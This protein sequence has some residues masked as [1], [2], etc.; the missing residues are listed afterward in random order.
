MIGRR[1]GPY[2]VLAKLGEGGMGE[3]YRA[4]DTRLNRDV[5]I[6]ILPDAFASDADR[7]ARFAR[8]AQTLASLNHPHIAQIYGLEQSSTVTALVMEL[9]EG[10][11]LAQRIARGPIPVDEALAIA[12]QLADG[13]EAAHEKGIIHRDLKPANIKL[14][15]DGTVKVLDFGLAKASEIGEREPGRTGDLAN[16]PTM[17]APAMTH[18]GIILG[19]AAYMSPE[20]A[21]GKPVDK[22][23]DIWAFGCVLYEML[24]GRPPFHGETVTDTLASVVKESA[25]LDRLPADT[26][27]H[28]QRLIERCLQK[29]PR[30]RLR[31]IGDAR[32]DLDAR[33]PESAPVAATLS[34]ARMMSV[35]A[36]GV[37]IGASVAAASSWALLRQAPAP[38]PL[39]TRFTISPPPG[40]RLYASAF[41][42]DIA[43]SA[44][45]TRV[46][47]RFGTGGLAIRS[48]DQLEPQIVPGIF[49]RQPVFSPDGRWIAFV[50]QSREL[51]KVSIA[52]GP[53][54]SICLMPGVGPRGA[55]WGPDEII[56]FA[57]NDPATGLLSVP[58]GGGDPKVLT[59]PKV[60]KD[61]ALAAGGV[62]A[63][64]DHL[65]PSLLPDGRGV[66]FTV[67]EGSIEKAQIAVLDLKTGRWKTVL[68]G[69]AAAE[70]VPSGHLVYAGAGT[71]RAV[72]FDPDLMDVVGDPVS[73]S[74][75]VSLIESTGA[76][77]FAV[78]PSGT[79]AY[80][81]DGAAR[82]AQR[83]LVWVDRQG[84]EEPVGAPP[85][86][87][88]VARIA[89]DATRIAV[90]TLDLER[91]IWNWDTTRR[92]LTRLTFGPTQDDRPVWM[93]EGRHIIFGSSRMSA[94]DLFLRA[95]DGAGIDEPLASSANPKAVTQV[96]DDGL[97]AIGVEF[98][99]DTANDIVQWRIAGRGNRPSE[100][101]LAT[102]FQESNPAIS[103]DGRYLA[104]QSDESGPL[105]VYVR[106]YPKVND[107]RWQV[108]TAG[109][110][111]PL[112]SPNGRELFYVAADGSLMVVPVHTSGATFK[113][114]NP[115]KLIEGKYIMTSGDR[116]YD[117]SPDGKRFLMIK[118]ADGKA[119][120]GAS[121]SC[122]TSMK[123]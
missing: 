108:S 32:L 121:S 67:W 59:T 113:Q 81:P 54:V 91:D 20:Q 47:F 106:P 116:Q 64:G 19:T 86:T 118:D 2:E 112:W 6:K 16:S 115:E 72:R 53:A 77:N 52:G 22:R 23:A 17:A 62:T 25:D 96:T 38:L 61:A 9:V 110:T 42:R 94:S 73:L 90:S 30:M 34:R 87:Y 79:V 107:G 109:G 55:A 63:I 76:A 82:G 13:L 18:A 51:K 92:T 4:R 120:P 69:G 95:A 48:I 105:E 50:E 7:V 89:P 31:D 24:T 44:D 58:A 8:E 83:S 85:R 65:F 36:A 41:D 101:L 56:I 117:I 102:T 103:R 60:N 12:R 21:R 123:S 97:I 1:L 80:M 5:A 45:G 29:D 93:P 26:P 28:I 35:G 88:Q 57:T 46:A 75:R 68:H 114:G 37:I 43:L 10:E 78:S 3:V 119:T 66:V 122:R 74:A 39:V 111:R 33:I 100:P 70:Y 99:P 98:R 40:E 15:P 71:L 14:T 27:I 11:D 84:R 104:Y 49:G